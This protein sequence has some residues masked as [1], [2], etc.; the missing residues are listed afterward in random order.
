MKEK[1]VA[2][3]QGLYAFWLNHGGTKTWSATVFLESKAWDVLNAL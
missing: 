2:T 1:D 3:K